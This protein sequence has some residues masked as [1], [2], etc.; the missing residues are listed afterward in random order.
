MVELVM[1]DKLIHCDTLKFDGKEE[2]AE[3]DVDDPEDDV[4][5]YNH[6]E[7]GSDK[8]LCARKSLGLDQKTGMFTPG[9]QM[10]ILP[11]KAPAPYPRGR[12]NS[13]SRKAAK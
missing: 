2:S 3:F 1:D 13:P 8:V 7:D 11:F 5:I 10:L 6:G 9:G 4:R 12:D